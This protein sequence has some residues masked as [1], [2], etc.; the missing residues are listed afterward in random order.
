MAFLE[1]LTFTGTLGDLSAYRMRGSDKIILRRKGGAS[2]KKIKTSPQFAVP[3]LNM[4]EF[5]G[6]SAMG[7]QVRHMLIPVR[8]LAD[9]NISGPINKLLKVV[10]K[11][12]TV[13]PLGQR[14]VL[15]SRHPS[16]LEGFSLNDHNPFDSM[17]RGSLTWS[18]DRETRSAR[19]E[20]PALLREINFFPQNKH[21]LFCITVAL[22]IVPD[23]T[24]NAARKRYEPPAWYDSSFGARAASTPWYSAL[25]GSPDTTLEVALNNV[26]AD[27]SYSLMLSIGIC[28]GSLYPGGLIEQVK[29]VGAAKVLALKGG[30][31]PG[32][33]VPHPKGT[34]SSE[35]V[36][37]SADTKTSSSLSLQDQN[38]TLERSVPVANVDAPGN[39][40]YAYTYT[41]RTG[42]PV[43]PASARGHT[44]T[45]P[46]SSQ[47]A[48]INFQSP[49]QF[50]FSGEDPRQP[51]RVPVAAATDE[52]AMVPLFFFRDT[53]EPNLNFSA[54]CKTLFAFHLRQ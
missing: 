22:G 46:L 29:R 24:F 45:I 15:L 54:F 47:V 32:S 42:D 38:N 4:M 8:R 6:C 7:K 44:Y 12:D 52:N 3:R 30:N 35:T 53:Y 37:P 41:L 19:I 5:G 33:R 34:V 17:I 25:E 26:P 10:Q 39:V 50:F 23:F 27:E 51:I 11:Q 1:E 48:S 20:I 28:F 2:K 16:L 9:H 49:E 21:S 14:S 31:D 36:T 13:S 18:L 43:E 40:S